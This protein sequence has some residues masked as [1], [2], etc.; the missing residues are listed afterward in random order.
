MYHNI[1]L[2]PFDTDENDEEELRLNESI[3]VSLNGIH[4]LHLLLEYDT[5]ARAQNMIPF[6]V[7]GSERNVIIDGKTV[8]GR[9]NRWGVINIEDERHC[10]FV[11]LRNFLTRL[12]A[13]SVIVWSSV[14]NILSLAQDTPPGPHRD[15]RTDPL[16]GLPF[17]AVAR[18]QRDGEGVCTTHCSS[19]IK[20]QRLCLFFT[21]HFAVAIR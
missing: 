4:L 6:A 21:S 17:E 12:V 20:P 5:H 11:Y 7:V 19:R 18:T 9:K 15:D 2:Y 16:R 10:E 8:R 1:V 14:S 3:R 13:F